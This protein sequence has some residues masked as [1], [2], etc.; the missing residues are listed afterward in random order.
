MGKTRNWNKQWISSGKDEA[1]RP[2]PLCVF[3]IKPHSVEVV[4]GSVG[5]D[6][7]VLNYFCDSVS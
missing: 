3:R 6:L 1:E 7:T 5:L 4:M 2:V